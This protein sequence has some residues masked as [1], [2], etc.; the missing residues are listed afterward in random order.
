MA[1]RARSR[2]ALTAG[3][4]LGVGLMGSADEIVFHQLLQWHSFYVSTT[5]YWRIV[6]D[7]AFHLFTTLMLLLASLRL[8]ADRRR[9]SQVMSGRP[10]WAGALIAGGCF[11][12]FDGVVNHKLLR[13]HPVREGVD[14]ILP[15]DIAWVASAL[16]LLGAGWLV[17]RAIPRPALD[18]GNGR[19]PSP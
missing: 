12:L 8:W 10:F 6:S 15:Y 7:G 5:A 14:N 9:L 3:A 18:G 11:Q 2:S 17:W 13:L 16:A 1:M 19:V 4:L